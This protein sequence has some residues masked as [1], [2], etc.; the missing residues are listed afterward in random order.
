MATEAIRCP[1]CGGDPIV[2]KGLR[3][4]GWAETHCRCRECGLNGPRVAGVI[5]DFDAARM[6]WNEAAREC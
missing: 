4:D 3:D 5:S 1:A 6:A 2:I